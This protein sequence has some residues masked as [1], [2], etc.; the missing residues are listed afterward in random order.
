MG[1]WI[2]QAVSALTNSA[3]HAKEKEHLV[4][5]TTCTITAIILGTLFAITAIILGAL[6]SIC[7]I[8]RRKLP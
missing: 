1:G 6:F 5:M 2:K 4:I 8:A 3:Q 7:I